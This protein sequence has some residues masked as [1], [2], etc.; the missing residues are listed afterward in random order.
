MPLV[1]ATLGLERDNS[2]PSAGWGD[3]GEKWHGRPGRSECIPA[4]R[5]MWCRKGSRDRRLQF[6]LP[7]G[8]GQVRAAGISSPPLRTSAI[9]GRHLHPRGGAINHNTP[10]KRYSSVICMRLAFPVATS[11]EPNVLLAG[12][13]LAAEDS[14]FQ[15]KRFDRIHSLQS[16]G[17]TIIIVSHDAASMTEICSSAVWLHRGQLSAQGLAS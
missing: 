6:G 1:D 16:A 15:K 2:T 10:V 7:N 3:S 11:M 4:D 5:N 9:A 8:V 17:R 13:M 12:E 14:S